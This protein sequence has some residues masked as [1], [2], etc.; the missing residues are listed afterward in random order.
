[1][2]APADQLVRLRDLAS[3]MRPDERATLLLLAERM[4]AGRPDVGIERDV[5]GDVFAALQDA[6]DSSLSAVASLV[7]ARR[8][9]A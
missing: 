1:M 2:H 8:W 6:V 9:R 5:D 4:A 7:R 3:Q